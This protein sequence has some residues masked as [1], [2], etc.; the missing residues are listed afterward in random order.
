MEMAGAPRGTFAASRRGGIERA[1]A[2]SY[3]HRCHPSRWF[4]AEVGA[5]LLQA[6]ETET[7]CHALMVLTNTEPTPA[8]GWT[9]EL[10]MP[11]GTRIVDYW[12]AVMATDG[13]AVHLH[14]QPCQWPDRAARDCQFR[15]RDRG[16]WQPGRMPS[17]RERVCRPPDAVPPTTT[18]ANIRVTGVTVSS[19]SLSWDS[20]RDDLGVVQYRIPG[21]GGPGA[22]C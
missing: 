19:V 10:L 3:H 16:N 18:P 7:G 13:R 6:S 15:L 11:D 22:R 21:C 2:R 5:T 20:A 4:A 9:V 1:R 14:E 17:Q 8:D 12:G